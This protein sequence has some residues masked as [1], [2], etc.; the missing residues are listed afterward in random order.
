MTQACPNHVA[1]MSSPYESLA[2]TAPTSD[3]CREP[4]LMQITLYAIFSWA[5]SQDREPRPKPINILQ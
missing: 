2:S 5:Q 3:T 4:V 1:S